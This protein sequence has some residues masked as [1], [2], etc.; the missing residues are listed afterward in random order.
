MTKKQATTPKSVTSTVSARV[1]KPKA[2]RVT[3][4]KHKK[5]TA[6]E[7]VVTIEEVVVMTPAM[8]GNPLETISRLAYGYWEARG[9]QGGDPLAD[10]VRAEEA[11]RQSLL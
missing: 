8:D 6:A 4:S 5:A 11:Y 10:W 9:C 2:P 3:S 1:A 7:P